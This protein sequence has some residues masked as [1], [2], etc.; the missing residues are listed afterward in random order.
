V[1]FVWSSPCL[2][3]TDVS[4][5]SGSQL[6]F[7]DQHAEDEVGK[8]AAGRCRRRPPWGVHLCSRAPGRRRA[9]LS[10]NAPPPRGGATSISI[11]VHTVTVSAIA[12]AIF[13]PPGPEGSIGFA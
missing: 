12:A 3:D 13:R 1:K 2:T 6:L 4:P 8:V 10:G 11:L 5:H 9:W 7:V